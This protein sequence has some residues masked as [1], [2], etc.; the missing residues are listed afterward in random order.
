M[1]VV[2]VGENRLGFG[3]D[4]DRPTERQGVGTHIRCHDQIAKHL[5][6]QPGGVAGSGRPELHEAQD[7]PLGMLWLSLGTVDAILG[8]SGRCRQ[9]RSDRRQHK[10]AKQ[11]AAHG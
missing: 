11:Q 1:L 9:H 8:R 4:I 3:E 5:G 10:S 6:D 2:Q 7:A